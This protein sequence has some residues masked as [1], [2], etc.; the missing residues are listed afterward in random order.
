MVHIE[1]NNSMVL[2]TEN[3]NLIQCKGNATQYFCS[4]LD[5]GNTNLKDQSLQ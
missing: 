3:T 4:L 2:V 5:L 1:N